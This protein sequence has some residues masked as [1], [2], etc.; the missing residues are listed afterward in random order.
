MIPTVKERQAGAYDFRKY[1][2]NLC[3]LRNCS[4][5]S[6]IT[7]HVDNG[8]LDIS[9]DRI[10]PAPLNPLDIEAAHTD[11]PIDVTPST[12]E[13]IRMAIRQIK[14]RKAVEP[15]NTPAGALMLD[16]EGIRK[17]RTL[18]H[19]SFEGSSINDDGLE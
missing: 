4:P 9:A 1:Y 3:A 11:L 7:S 6:V 13:E 8:V 10:K 15:D 16:I 14:S 2:E 17:N 12:I 19:L 5:L 18:K